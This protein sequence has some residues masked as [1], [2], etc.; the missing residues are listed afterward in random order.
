MSDVSRRDAL[1]L[2]TAGLAVS[3]GALLANAA[4]GQEGKK[5][6]SA[7]DRWKGHKLADPKELEKAS[8]PTPVKLGVEPPGN[9]APAADAELMQENAAALKPMGVQPVATFWG[10]PRPDLNGLRVKFPNQ[11]AIYLIDRGYR[12]W[13]PDPATYNNLFRDWNGIVVDI[14]I[15]EIPLAPQITSGAVLVRA[16]GTAPVY[17]VDQGM[18]RWIVSPAMMDKYYFAWNRIYVLP[19]GVVDPIPVGPNIDS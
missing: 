12:R 2:T 11:P 15:D 17:L 13:I 4:R 8:K 16:D 1:K 6:A 3:A 14:D 10:S 7:E 18:K 5:L 9:K 19:R